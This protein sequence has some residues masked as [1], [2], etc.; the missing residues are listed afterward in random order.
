MAISVPTKMTVRKNPHH[1]QIT[2]KSF[3]VSYAFFTPVI[4]AYDVF[5]FPYSYHWYISASAAPNSDTFS[6]LFPLLSDLLLIA[7][8]YA[9]MTVFLNTTTISVTS[10]VISV[11]DG[12]FPI[13]GNKR[14]ASKDVL[15]LYCKKE[16]VW[17]KF[18]VSTDFS[19]EAVMDGK[20]NVTLLFNL[21]QADQA[22]FVEQEIEKFLNIED[23]PIKG[24][25][26]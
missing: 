10:N 2:R 6:F 20:S 21:K 12:P 11:K 19:V 22:L 5:W 25:F 15:Q 8:N 23:K 4:I 3:D 18:Y 16:N 17:N 14:L 26:K 1:L 13:W 9:L 7:S 24:E